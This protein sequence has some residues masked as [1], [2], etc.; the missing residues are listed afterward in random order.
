MLRAECARRRHRRQ[1]GSLICA[2]QALEHSMASSKRSVSCSLASRARSWWSLAQCVSGPTR[3]FPDIT[4]TWP[5]RRPS[6]ERRSQALR[7]SRRRL[8]PPGSCPPVDAGTGGRTSICSAE[9]TDG[10][11]GASA[12]NDA[13]GAI[14]LRF[15]LRPV[16]YACKHLPRRVKNSQTGEGLRCYNVASRCAC[17]PVDQEARALRRPRG[18]GDGPGFLPRRA[19]V[20]RLL[21]LAVRRALARG[22]PSD[23]H[24]LRG[25][26]LDGRD[27]ERSMH[28][29]TR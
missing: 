23:L 10:K 4:S 7:P 25:W 20:A 2:M 17:G 12:G 1:A 27:P 26:Q 28:V 11:E 5:R 24:R 13:L 15:G 29:P 22:V 21:A 16:H 14:K 3:L 19:T 8:A 9:D 6:L 18:V